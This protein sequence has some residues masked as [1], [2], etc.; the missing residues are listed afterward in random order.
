MAKEIY[1][2]GKIHPLGREQNLSELIASLSLDGKRFA[3]ERNKEIVPRS[4]Y[5]SVS[6]ENGDRI[7]IVGFV[8]GG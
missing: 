6:L 5:A 2:N 4:A 3:I 1:V 8:G 7:E